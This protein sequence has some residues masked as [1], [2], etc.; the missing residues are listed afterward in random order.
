MGYLLVKGKDTLVVVDLTR[1]IRHPELRKLAPYD[2]EE[3]IRKRSHA[4]ER[5][6]K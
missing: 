2:I 5:V 6:N 3:F 1:G 4:R